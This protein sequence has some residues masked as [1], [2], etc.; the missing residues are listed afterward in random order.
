LLDDKIAAVAVV[1]G[2]NVCDATAAAAAATF[3][4]GFIDGFLD[5]IFKQPPI[6]VVVGGVGRISEAVT[7]LGRFSSIR[8]KLLLLVLLVLLTGKLVNN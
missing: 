5:L 8:S 4:D 7:D 6:G 1:V 2:G 3:I